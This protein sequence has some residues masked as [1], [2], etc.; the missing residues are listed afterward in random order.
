MDFYSL[1]ELR[2]NDMK[3]FI[4]MA[5]KHYGIPTDSMNALLGDYELIPVEDSDP[6]GSDAV[7]MLL[8]EV[9]KEVDLPADVIAKFQELSVVH[10]PITY[11]D[12][13]LLK[14]IQKAWGNKTLIRSQLA[15]YTRTQ[16]IK[17]IKITDLSEKWERWVYLRFMENDIRYD[18]AGK[19]INPEDRILVNNLAEQVEDLY[20]VPNCNH[21]RK[22][23]KK[24]R[25]I[26]E[27][28]KQ[29]IRYGAPISA[30][31]KERGL[32]GTL[33]ELWMEVFVFDMYS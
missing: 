21:T 12:V 33:F 30:V 17:L 11:D 16:R 24:I 14:I 19:M 26:A 10:K 15:N 27:N 1:E 6:L 13:E 8:Y 5:S 22:R 25:E 18:S 28:D 9:A 4:E 7:P 20:C 29:K 32:P 31:L 2:K 3:R 23:I